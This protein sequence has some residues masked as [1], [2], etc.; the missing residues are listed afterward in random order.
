MKRFAT[1]LEGKLKFLRKVFAVENFENLDFIGSGYRLTGTTISP[2]LNFP[3]PL[4]A[5]EK[6]HKFS[7]FFGSQ[8]R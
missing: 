7:K 8:T 4:S 3:R 6:F 2:Y 5:G 1:F